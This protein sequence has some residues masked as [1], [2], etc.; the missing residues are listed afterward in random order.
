VIREAALARG[1]RDFVNEDPP[2]LPRARQYLDSLLDRAS[3][4]ASGRPLIVGGFSQGGMLVCDTIVRSGRPVS[5][6][7]LLSAS[8]VAYAAWVPHLEA[9]NVRG[10]AALVSH[11]LSDADLAFSAGVAL[12]DCLSAGGADV[13]WVPFDQGHEI[14]LV[15]WRHVRKLVTKVSPTGGM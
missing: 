2:D 10:L 14:P 11:G 8:R 1:P 9:G 7:L 15:V 4:E 12:R 5:G 3:E 6:M 13:T